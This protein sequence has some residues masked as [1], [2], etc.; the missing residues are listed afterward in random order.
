M[1]MM[2]KKVA[3]TAELIATLRSEQSKSIASLRGIPTGETVISRS[4]N[5][6]TIARPAKAR[7]VTKRASTPLVSLYGRQHMVG[8][9]HKTLDVS[10]SH[11]DLSK[12]YQRQQNRHSALMALVG[13]IIL[14]LSIIVL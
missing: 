10:Q 12:Q 8:S 9:S 2:N 5:R 11:Y 3:Y 4:E 7:P 1:E 13:G 14:G 6:K